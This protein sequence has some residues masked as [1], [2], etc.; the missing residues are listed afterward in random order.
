MTEE[1]VKA[2]TNFVKV[3][4]YKVLSTLKISFEGGK[5]TLDKNAEGFVV[6][7]TN[8]AGK[9]KSGKLTFNDERDGVCFF[10]GLVGK[11][12]PIAVQLPKS[13]GLTLTTEDGQ[14]M[15][16]TINLTTSGKS[17]YINFKTSDWTG[18]AKLDATLNNRQESIVLY[19]NHTANR[20]MDIKVALAFDGKEMLRLEANGMNSPYTDEEI[21]SDDFKQLRDFG[22]FFSGAYDMLKVINDKNANNVAFTINDNI[23]Y[24]GNVNDVVRCLLALGNM[25]K[26]Y[27]TNPSFEAVD[28]NTQELNKYV[29]FTVSQK[30]T[31]ITAKGS[32]ITFRKAMN[33]NEYLPAVALQFEGETEPQAIL[34]RMTET[35]LKNYEKIFDNLTQLTL[36]IGNTA[37]QI[38]DKFKTVAEAFKF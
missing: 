31:G 19:A 13:I 8:K 16:G 29:Q 28:A 26:M 30:N 35:D 7:V 37:V 15:S 38:G 3:D 25:T 24:K 22:P 5:Y 18:D 17:R 14:V 36:D 34:D 32:F 12:V 6:E 11:V 23:T 2:L 33:R 27:G 21:A 20:E 4:A 10:A 1:E 9:K